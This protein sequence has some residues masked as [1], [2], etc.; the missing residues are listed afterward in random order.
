MHKIH[1][2]KDIVCLVGILTNA[3]CILQIHNS[4]AKVKIQKIVDSNSGL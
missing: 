2:E 1:S 4:R 3:K